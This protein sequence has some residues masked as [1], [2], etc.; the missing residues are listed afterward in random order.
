MHRLT[1]RCRVQIETMLNYTEEERNTLYKQYKQT[2]NSTMS[3]KAGISKQIDEIV[4]G[5]RTQPVV[6]VMEFTSPGKLHMA[7]VNIKLKEDSNE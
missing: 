3:S 6:Y 4:S 1:E 7:D 5:K 2:K